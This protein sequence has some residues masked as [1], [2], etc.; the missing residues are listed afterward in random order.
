[1]RLVGEQGPC[2]ASQRVDALE[3]GTEIGATGLPS[4]A[5]RAGGLL[6]RGERL[7]GRSLQLPRPLAPSV[8]QLAM[9]LAER[10]ATLLRHDEA[11]L[12]DVAPV[13]LLRRL[14]SLLELAALLFALL[15]PAHREADRDADRGDEGDADHRGEHA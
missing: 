9:E 8:A 15:L 3:L 7:A 11:H 1:G 14:A 2:F 12:V 6:G 13:G 10:V 5:G 4:G